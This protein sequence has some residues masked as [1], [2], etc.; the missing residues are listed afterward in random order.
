MAKNT[1]FNFNNVFNVESMLETAENNA[2]TFAGFITNDVARE[3]TEAY[4]NAGFE[5][6]RLAVKTNTAVVEKLQ[7]TFSK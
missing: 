5:T 2:K 1:T 3:V 6:A 4:F 7:S